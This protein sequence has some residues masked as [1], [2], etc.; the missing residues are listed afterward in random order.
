M[1]LTLDTPASERRD[2]RCVDCGQFTSR[3]DVHFHGPKRKFRGR[4]KVHLFREG[5]GMVTRCDD[6]EAAR[7]LL[8]RKQTH[9]YGDDLGDAK[10]MFAEG[11]GRVE[12]GR[13]NVV[14]PESDDVSWWW[15]RLDDNAKGPG[16]TTAV[17]WA[18]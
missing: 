6:P 2:G 18:S 14:A 9:E 1:S 12:R 4:P 7:A 8:I 15:M 17:V 16:I 5:G 10:A 3:N 11:K 13:I